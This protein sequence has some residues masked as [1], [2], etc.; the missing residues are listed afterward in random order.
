MKVINNEYPAFPQ[1]KKIEDRY[2]SSDTY[3]T[4][5]E[6]IW[7]CNL[8]TDTGSIYT[9]LDLSL[10]VNNKSQSLS[11]DLISIQKSSYISVRDFSILSGYNIEADKEGNILLKKDG[12]V[13]KIFN[14]NNKIFINGKYTN[15]KAVKAEGSYYVPLR[16]SMGWVNGN[17]DSMDNSNLYL[18]IK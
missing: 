4:Y 1:C 16:A 14:E 11:K 9:H 15:V 8:Y 13:I 2:V 18:S 10:Y 7:D 17:I 12:K 3:Y 6:R 5:Y